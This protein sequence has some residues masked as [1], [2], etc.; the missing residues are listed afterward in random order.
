MSEQWRNFF[1]A[2]SDQRRRGRWSGTPG[3]RGGLRGR[4]HRRARTE[5]RETRR[6]CLGGSW[7]WGES[8]GEIPGAFYRPKWSGRGVARGGGPAALRVRSQHGRRHGV[9]A[10]CRAV[11]RQGRARAEGPGRGR[12]AAVATVMPLCALPRWCLLKCP[13][14][15]N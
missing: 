5:K 9:L 12:A 7:E 14:E 15:K 2:T 10:R 13:K 3:R 4:R 8:Y 11:Q 1:S 6:G